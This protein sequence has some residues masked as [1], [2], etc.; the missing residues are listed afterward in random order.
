MNDIF[1]Y[2]A[3]ADRETL[4]TG[5]VAWLL[6]REGAHGLGATFLKWVCEKSRPMKSI[7]ETVIVKVEERPDKDRR[8]DISL[9]QHPEER[10][11]LVI[12]VKSKTGGTKAQLE[13]YADKADTVARIGF[14]EWNWLDLC[15]AEQERFPLIKFSEIADLIEQEY[16]NATEAYKMLLVDLSNHLRTE[17]HFFNTYE[18]YFFCEE[19][20]NRRRTPSGQS[21]L[22]MRFYHQLYWQWFDDTFRDE[23]TFRKEH[24]WRHGSQVS[25]S[26]YASMIQDVGPNE[27]M[28]R[29][30]ADSIEL[31]DGIGYWIHAEVLDGH[32]LLAENESTEVGVIQLRLYN[33]TS[34]RKI[35][36]AELYE[37]LMTK[38][39]A[40]KNAGFL[41]P[42]KRPAER[43]YSFGAL[44]RRLNVR[45]LRYSNLLPLIEMLIPK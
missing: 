36:N 31:P 1:S 34:N 9:R 29:F 6:D 12:E 30:P 8:F 41:L 24:G 13:D 44:T 23:R 3:P 10:P 37:V 39:D 11:I 25:G 28:I 4:L 40:V 15:P 22:S 33:P 38:A 16:S 32:G 14:D 21:R 26:W 45:D 7:P 19:E 42:T 5:I 27:R 18:K 2:L 35:T 43:Y 17:S 20:A